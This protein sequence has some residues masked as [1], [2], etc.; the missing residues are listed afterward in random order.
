[1]DEAKLD[2]IRDWPIP[3]T[4]KEVQFFL[5]FANFYRKFINKY[6][7]V[8]EP[9]TRLT[10]KEHGFLWG[11]EQQRAFDSLKRMFCEAPILG[12]YNPELPIV[13]ETD[14]SD[15]AI[16]ACLSQPDE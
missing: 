4:V 15:Y 9:L 12:I 1:M 10:R 3:K 13:M 16:G 11:E 14:A 8:C 5:G 2:A 6:A 7:A